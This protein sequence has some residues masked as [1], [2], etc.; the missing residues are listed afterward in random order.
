MTA[1]VITHAP[2][3]STIAMTAPVLSSSNVMS[4]ILPSSIQNV[5]EAPV[6]LNPQVNLRQLPQRDIA[7]ARS[8]ALPTSRC[9][10]TH[11]PRAL[12]FW[13][14]CD[15][16]TAT[17]HAKTLFAALQSSG[18]VPAAA[19]Q[20]PHLLARYNPPFT[21]WWM[22]KNEVLIDLAGCEGVKL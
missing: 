15:E 14:N 21:L 17:S 11:S 5:A 6:P 18:I 12:T 22:K 9:L 4:F 16:D 13:G 1:P 10:T 2:D 20:P 7:Y 19:A 8:L 3:S